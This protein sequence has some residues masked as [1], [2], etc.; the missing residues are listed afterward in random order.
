MLGSSPHATMQGSARIE[1]EEE[2][3]EDKDMQ[4]ATAA[5]ENLC[6]STQ[7]SASKPQA[8][9]LGERN[10]G[11]RGLKEGKRGGQ[12]DE[13]RDLRRLVR[14]QDVMIRTLSRSLRDLEAEAVAAR[15]PML[16]ATTT[17]VATEGE[18]PDA[19][20]FAYE[21]IESTRRDTTGLQLELLT[22]ELYS[23]DV[24]ARAHTP[25]GGVGAPAC[26]PRDAASEWRPPGGGLAS[27][28]PF[29]I[30]VVGWS[31]HRRAI[32]RFVRVG[33]A[34]RARTCRSSP[35]MEG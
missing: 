17:T 28:P 5:L 14:Q 24:R 21:L 29:L 18:S 32:T 25:S 15:H 8:R 4:Q 16:P 20:K 3:E 31:C 1:E 26:H 7:P 34:T 13:L 27:W 12:R 9:V 11:G 10:V 6:V 23:L 19:S 35:R 33:Q 2:D 22:R 30:A